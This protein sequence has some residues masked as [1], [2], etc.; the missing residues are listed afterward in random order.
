M[1]DPADLFREAICATLG[2]APDVIE[3]GR[4]HRF[5][6]NDR[7]GDLAGWCR[8]YADLRGGVFGCMRQ[9]ISETWAAT[10]RAS[11]SVAERLALSRHIESAT[12]E[13]E[14]QQREEWAAHAR[15]NAELW[16]R[17]VSLTNSDPVARYLQRRIGIEVQDAPDCLRLHPALPYWHDGNKLGTYPAMVAPLTAADGGPVALHRTYLSA[18]GSK[19]DVPT[20]KK[21]TAAS[22]PLAGACIRLRPARG[23]V[24]GIAEGIETALAASVASGVPTVSAYCAGAMAGYSWPAGVQSL[25]IF[26]DADKAGREAADR[27]RA[28]ALQAGL[29]VNVMMPSAAGTD[30]CDVWAQ[31]EAVAVEGGAA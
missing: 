24:I 4:F 21:L 7:R 1:A 5:A 23:G 20:V 26:A 14:R 22:G 11:M 30:W 27:L 28:R 29:R 3:P 19:A 10:Q 9:G 8:L 13:R 17:C 18:D 31:R 16:S 2:H 6:T 12:R 15:R 25:V